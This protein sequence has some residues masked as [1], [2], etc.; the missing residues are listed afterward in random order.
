METELNKNFNNG[1]E[2]V[3]IDLLELVFLARRNWRVIVLVALVCAILV[4]AFTYFFIP[5]KYQATA[6][7]YI[8]SSSSD[9]VINLTD[10]QIAS[11]LTS[12]YKEL[13]MMRPMME[14]TIQNLNLDME[15]PALSKMVDVTNTTGT[16]ILNI[17]ATT[18]DPQLSADIANEVAKLSISW[19]PAI[20]ESNEPHIVQ[21]AIVPKT[22]S[23]PSYKKNVLIG[24]LA[25]AILAYGIY[26]IRYLL[27][28]TIKS[29]DDMEKYFGVVPLT[30]IPED[31]AANDGSREGNDDYRSV[32]KR[33]FTK[34]KREDKYKAKSKHGRSKK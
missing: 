9:S 15:A 4:G 21:D 31:P 6:K 29:A 22:K 19:L 7:I 27:D 10:L 13:I 11:N 3:E 33:L 28:D 24:F 26:V 17:T 32:I 20:M 1:E 8:V 30:S 5:P 23:S 2:E 16:R 25:G 18:L 34:T 12:D 14:S